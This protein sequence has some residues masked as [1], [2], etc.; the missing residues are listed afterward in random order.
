M[1]D[2]TKNECQCSQS[3]CGCAAAPEARC[4]CQEKCDCSRQCRCGNDCGC[5]DGR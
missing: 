5:P 1:N 2:E 4:T 3:A